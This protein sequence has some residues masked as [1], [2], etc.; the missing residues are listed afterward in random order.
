M[1][2]WLWETKGIREQPHLI[3]APKSTISNWMREFKKWAPELKVI[4]LNPKKEVR[5]DIIAE[6]RR[7]G[8]NVCVT[9]YD[10]LHRCPELRTRFKWYL[11]VFD[12]AHKLKNTES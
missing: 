3:V 5:G 7:P 10:A 1:I 11:I 12:E 8:M 6:M 2:C 4:N 9:T